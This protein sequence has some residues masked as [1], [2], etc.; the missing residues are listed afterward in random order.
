MRTDS[1]FYRLAY[2]AGTPR[3]D[4]AEPRPELVELTQGR[5][6]GRALDLGC[7][8]GT[9]VLYLARRGWDAVGV[10]FVPAAIAAARKRA[11]SSGSS[12]TFIAGDVTR[13]PEAGVDGSFDLVLD[14]GCYH[15]VPV[16]RRDSYAAGVAS[17]TRPGSDLYIA[18]ISHPPVIWR[19]VGA[20]GLSADD[21]QQRFGGDFELVDHQMGGKIGRAGNFAFFHLIRK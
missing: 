6:P 15:G 10:D 13:L 17:V 8:T 20:R 7:G 2:R 21:L 12:A 3:W 4:S 14:I 16:T 9:D 5:L 1:L 11:T 18:G 19:L